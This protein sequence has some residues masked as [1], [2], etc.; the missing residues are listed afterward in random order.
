MERLGV[1]LTIDIF[2]SLLKRAARVQDLHNYTYTLHMMVS[3]GFAPDGYSWVA[4][5]ALCRPLH[6]KM[7]IVDSMRSKGLL[8]HLP[9]LRRTVAQLV[10]GAFALWL[11]QGRMPL[12]FLEFMKCSWGPSWISTAAMNH[13]LHELRRRHLFEDSLQMWKVLSKLY[14]YSL[15]T[16]SVN[17][18]ISHYDIPG[19]F[20]PV[21]QFLTLL[22]EQSNEGQ[23]IRFD[24]TTYRILYTLARRFHYYNLARVVWRY[25]CT[26]AC[27]NR[28]LEHRMW[29]NV[30]A[31][32][33]ALEASTLQS[34]DA[35]TWLFGK[36]VVGIDSP[37]VISRL[38]D[39]EVSRKLVALSI[40]P[41]E[42]VSS[43]LSSGTG[44]NGPESSSSD[45]P[46]T[47]TGQPTKSTG[48]SSAVTFASFSPLLPLPAPASSVDLPT[49]SSPSVAVSDQANTTSLA[50]EDE[51]VD[52][53]PIEVSRRSSSRADPSS[54]APAS[55]NDDS[56]AGASF[57]LTVP[58]TREEELK[59]LAYA[60]FRRDMRSCLFLKPER[61]VLEM[62][63]LA[64]R[65]DQ[66]W[67]KRRVPQ[68]QS[69]D[70]LVRYAL[71]VPFR[72]KHRKGWGI[73]TLGPD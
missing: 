10:P 72:L 54:P 24:E 64:L 48:E 16:I 15:D 30:S 9:T 70:W 40:C 56:D 13:M 63:L 68:T 23:R 52:M 57:A 53:P 6:L 32:I 66:D 2:N 43:H 58:P 8:Q 37:E 55:S 7:K 33:S 46:P 73:Y 12:D 39:K 11:E 4:M 5:L 34:E 31:S 61:P 41:D 25:A 50:K 65:L 17:T 1:P 67:I 71:H 22:G 29:Q 26:T 20:E 51:R 38:G 36:I 60:M 45:R 35:V 3:K 44:V 14:R 19:D 21:M 69:V 42:E 18:M 47:E 27:V 59:Q 49:K 28:D 62:L